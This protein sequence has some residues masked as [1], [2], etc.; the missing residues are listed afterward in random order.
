MREI[1]TIIIGAGQ[2]GL[3]MSYY[4]SES[5]REHLILEKD[6]IGSAWKEDRWDSFT[7]VTPNK[8][9][10]LPGMEYTGD[11]PGGFMELS[12]WIDYLDSYAEFVDPPVKEGVEVT[13]VEA[14]D[15]RGRFMIHTDNGDYIADNAV[16]AAGTFQE[17]DIPAFGR[18]LSEEVM[19]LHSSEYRNPGQLPDGGVLVVGSAQSGCQ[20]AEELNQAGRE[21]FLSTSAVRRLPRTYRG[22]DSMDWL[23]K[24][25]IID[26]TVDELDSPAERF[27]PNPHVS[28]K[29]GG[30]TINLHRFAEQG[31][32]LLGHLE[33]GEGAR[34]EFAEDLHDNMRFADN[35]AEEFTQGVDKFIEKA[36]LEVPEEDKP[37]LNSGFE[38]PV[39][40]E[41]DL[42]EAGIK[43]VIWATGYDHDFS[44]VDFPIYDEFGYPEQERGVTEIPGLYFL[45]LHWLH[46][47]KSGLQVGVGEDAAHI[48]DQIESH[49]RSPD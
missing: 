5:D 11:E 14:A 21:V 31:I 24:M 37:E 17:P 38:Q 7:L 12:D 42:E 27:A 28:G 47:I 44:W 26:Q 8:Q 4:L 16:V 1:D 15:E 35:F 10:Q 36:G 48:A 3:V 20:I 13:R 45:G 22:V 34:L 46:T 43:S 32:H 18:K 2:A 19:Q 25:G 39:R 23:V 33:E 9:I 30:H 41:L 6:K 49:N 40:T 29:D